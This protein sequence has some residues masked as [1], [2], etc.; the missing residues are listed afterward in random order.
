MCRN[1][2]KL[3]NDKAIKSRF[4]NIQDN[5]ARIDLTYVYCVLHLVRWP[6]SPESQVADL[7]HCDFLINR[8]FREMEVGIPVD[9]ST[10]WPQLQESETVALDQPKVH[11]HLNDNDLGDG[12]LILGTKR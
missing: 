10:W 7:A 9:A 4:S 1:L 6:D 5:L 11:L 2:E 8:V 12:K 3:R